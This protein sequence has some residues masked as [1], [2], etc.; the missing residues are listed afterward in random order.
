MFPFTEIAS[1]TDNSL[2]R[3][4][5]LTQTQGIESR[6][7]VWEWRDGGR[8]AFSFRSQVHLDIFRTKRSLFAL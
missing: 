3:L 6:D 5:W 2:A 4:L 8:A 1:P 7:W